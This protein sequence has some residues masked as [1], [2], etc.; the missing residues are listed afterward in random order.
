MEEGSAHSTHHNASLFRTTDQPRRRREHFTRT[1]NGCERCRTRRRKCQQPSQMLFT[2]EWT[3]LT[4]E[5]FT[6]DETRPRCRRCVDAKVQCQYV[7]RM[8][9]PYGG[10][11]TQ[12]T[13]LA[14]SRLGTIQNDASLS[15]ASGDTSSDGALSNLKLNEQRSLNGP[16]WTISGV[17]PDGVTFLID[18]YIRYIAPWVSLIRKTGVPL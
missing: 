18:Y 10:N 2:K 5:C 16:P 13:S 7:T 3:W 11:S 15:C 9:F 12:G 8:S 17:L 14:S 1:R 6:G 4:C